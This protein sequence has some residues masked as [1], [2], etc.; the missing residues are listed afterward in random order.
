LKI[1]LNISRRFNML[2]LDLTCRTC[3]RDYDV[4]DFGTS[5]LIHKLTENHCDDGEP[6]ESDEL[7]CPYCGAIS[8]DERHVDDIWEDD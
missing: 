1:G 7:K 5:F 8:Y 2:C 3:G 6:I 4:E